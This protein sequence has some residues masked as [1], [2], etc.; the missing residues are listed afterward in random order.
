MGFFSKLFNGRSARLEE[1]QGILCADREKIASNP[2][3]IMDDFA[4]AL[5]G[6]G[7][8]DAE[9][10]AIEHREKAAKQE[11]LDLC[12]Q[13]KAVAETMESFK[14]TKEDLWK[15]TE[16]LA[17]EGLGGKYKGKWMHLEAIARDFPIMVYYIAMDSDVS[18][19]QVVFWL[20]DYFKGR[21]TE[22]EIFAELGADA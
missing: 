10:R 13:D 1:L 7:P 20:M 5:S 6:K 15:M 21:A 11:Y 18:V 2:Y 22:V 14:L 17:K 8:S 19:Q 3:S 4:D 12:V 16:E 9:R